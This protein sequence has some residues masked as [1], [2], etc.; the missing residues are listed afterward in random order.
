MEKATA[1]SL[2]ICHPSK[3]HHSAVLRRTKKARNSQLISELLSFC[4]Q[5]QKIVDISSDKDFVIT[6]TK[7][8]I[9]QPFFSLNP[10]PCVPVKPKRLYALPFFHYEIPTVILAGLFASNGEEWNASW[11]NLL[12]HHTPE[13][14]EQ[15]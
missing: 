6:K 14:D 8:F 2:A 10:S 12:R 3:N 15:T 1:S 11:L 13:G 5:S 7:K 9:S 4:Q